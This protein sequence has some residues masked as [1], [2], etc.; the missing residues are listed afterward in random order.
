MLWK[1][2]T[3]L[4]LTIALGA[5][6]AAFELQRMVWERDRSL[7]EVRRELDDLERRIAA[8]E[9]E[10]EDIPAVDPDIEKAQA[11]VRETL[12][13]PASALF[14]DLR[15]VILGVCGRVNSKNRFGGYVGPRGFAVVSI[16]G[17][18]MLHWEF[19]SAGDER[20]ELKVLDHN[21]YASTCDPAA[22]LPDPELPT[23]GKERK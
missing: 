12:I 13:D 19:S 17:Y 6:L 11:L 8:N 23:F 15:R 14:T 10:K 1:A 20:W 16:G 5:G 21:M 3:I 7:S 22:K 9:K 2:A 4:F 18:Q